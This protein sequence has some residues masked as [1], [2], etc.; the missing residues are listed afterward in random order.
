M[1]N[2]YYYYYY[3][4]IMITITKF[5]FKNYGNQIQIDNP[6]Q[7]PAAAIVFLYINDMT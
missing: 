6:I 5:H 3:L 2:H 7:T 4:I 1:E